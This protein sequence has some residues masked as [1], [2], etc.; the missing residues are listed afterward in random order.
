VDS[1]ILINNILPN[2]PEVNNRRDLA[3]Y[4][5][6]LHASYLPKFNNSIHSNFPREFK[7]IG[8]YPN[9]FNPITNIVYEVPTRTD[10]EIKIYDILGN[11]INSLKVAAQN[12]GKHTITW[13]GKNSIN[14]DV[15]SG[16]YIYRFMA[17]PSSGQATFQSTSKFI[18]LK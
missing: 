7:L 18:L 6:N 8:N 13:N 17:S 12:P 3:E 14:T 5:F 2:D 10:V 4:L 15:A 9:P 11:L 16:V 1:F